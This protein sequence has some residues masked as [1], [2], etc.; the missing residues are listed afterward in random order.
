MTTEPTNFEGTKK[1]FYLHLILLIGSIFLFAGKPVPYSN[2]FLY[3]LRLEPNFLPNDWTFSQPANEHWLFNTI[4]S[5]PGY[6]FSLETV[7]WMGRIAVWILCLIPL[8]K[9]RQVLENPVL[10]DQHFN[11][12]MARPRTGGGQRRMDFR[13]F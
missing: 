5:L 4:F 7:G 8:D 13:R 9:N 6:L 10:G 12:F 2:E 1:N 11:F 3:L